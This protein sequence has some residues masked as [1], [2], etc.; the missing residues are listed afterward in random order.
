[1]TTALVERPRADATP[2]DEA[3][4]RRE[5]WVVSGCGVDD[6]R[7]RRVELQR[8]DNPEP[9][10]GTFPDDLDAWQHVADRAR[11]GSALHLQALALVDPI[12]RAL[13]E[14]HASRH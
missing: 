1:M 14:Q 9:G 7:R 8:L 6:G 2:F 12:E 13:I 4:A 3:A 10:E 11:Q 5:G